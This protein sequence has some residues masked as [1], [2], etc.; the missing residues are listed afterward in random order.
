MIILQRCQNHCSYVSH[1]HSQLQCTLQTTA[2]ASTPRVRVSLCT[3]IRV[4][5]HTVLCYSH[6]NETNVSTPLAQ[7]YTRKIQTVHTEAISKIAQKTVMHFSRPVHKCTKY[8]KHQFISRN[9]MSP[10]ISRP[11]RPVQ[12]KKQKIDQKIIQANRVST[13]ER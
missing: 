3:L 5:T 2:N 6:K 1:P 7:S 10:T 11:E 13:H 8:F 12:P 9:A 4:Y